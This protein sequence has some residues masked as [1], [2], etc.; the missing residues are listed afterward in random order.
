MGGF[1]PAAKAAIEEA[2]QRFGVL[3]SAP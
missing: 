3:L 1:S 2:C